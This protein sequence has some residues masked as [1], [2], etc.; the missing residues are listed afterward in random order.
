MRFISDN[1]FKGKRYENCSNVFLRLYGFTLKCDLIKSDFQRIRIFFSSFLFS[2]KKCEKYFGAKIPLAVERAMRS[3]SD[4][5]LC[6]CACHT[7]HRCGLY[8]RTNQ[9]AC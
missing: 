5:E 7:N 9:I 1:I 8:Q 6:M 4:G 3:V 2:V